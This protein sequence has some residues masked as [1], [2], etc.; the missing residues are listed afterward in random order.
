MKKH[1]TLKASEII[2]YL[3]L[4][5]V[6]IQYSFTNTQI[7][8]KG[9]GSQVFLLIESILFLIYFFQRKFKLKTAIS[10][11]VLMIIAGL[12]YYNTGASA[13]MIMIMAAILLEILDYSNVFFVIFIT[14]MIC[15]GIVVLLS[16]VGILNTYQRTITKAGKSI[17]SGYGLGFTHPNRLAY[18]ILF[19]SLMFICYKNNQLK[20]R[21]LLLI[22]CFNL[23]GYEITKSRTLLV[24]ILGTILAIWLYQS[25]YLK[26]ITKK[27]LRCI[28]I[29]IIPLC[30]AISIIIPLLML[31]ATGKLQTILYM[32]N[33]LFSSRFT[34]AYR[35]FLN[36]P[37]TFFG[38][39]NDF[40]ELET[41]YHYSTID[42]G[43]VRLLYA[44]GIVGFSLFIIFSILCVKTLIEKEEYIYVIV[45]I[46]IALWGISENVLASFAFN[47]SVIFWSEILKS[48]SFKKTL[49]RNKRRHFKIK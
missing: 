41:I 8:I 1:I 6:S 10:I 49:H 5:I 2:I 24:I 32:I 36:Y 40:S 9:V 16:I 43:Y 44:F 28:A 25:K 30:A 47:I 11:L 29:I 42:N 35:A 45:Y 19:L 38:G 15:F 31:T 37:I 13:F 21:N 27:I 39:T 4:I 33:G 7:E 20:K 18:V 48:I 34:H 12:T 46:A 26:K 22:I 14:R 23:V 17:V 3:F